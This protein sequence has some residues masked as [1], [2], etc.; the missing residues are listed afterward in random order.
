[1]NYKNVYYCTSCTWAVKVLPVQKS[2]DYL[3][4]LLEAILQSHSI[5]MFI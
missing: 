4:N 1:M 2:K 5:Y 3:K